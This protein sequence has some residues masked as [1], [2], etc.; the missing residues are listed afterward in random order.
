MNRN[1]DY[2]PSLAPQAHIQRS[3]FKGLSH[4]VKTSFNTGDIIPFYCEKFTL[5]TLSKSSPP[6]LFVC[7]PLLHP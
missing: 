6:R 5:V 3:T 1:T 7:R 4:S 2:S